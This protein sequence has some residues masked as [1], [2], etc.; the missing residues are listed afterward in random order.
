MLLL[1]VFALPAATPLLALTVSAQSQ[2]PI[3]CRQGGTHKC[4]MDAPPAGEAQL[5]TSCPAGLQLVS[6]LPN[7]AAWNGVRTLLRAPETIPSQ[8]PTRAAQDPRGQW[9]AARDSRGPPQA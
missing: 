3:C 9:I 2:L 5:R 1:L 7:Q 8:D 6:P 4:S